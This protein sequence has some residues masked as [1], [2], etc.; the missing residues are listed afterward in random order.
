MITRCW[1]RK[2]NI[3]IW[4]I[5]WSLVSGSLLA[6]RFKSIVMFLLMIDF[7]VTW[8][9]NSEQRSNKGTGFYTLLYHFVLT[10]SDFY[11]KLHG[12]Y[13][14]AD[15]A[16]RWLVG[17]SNMFA[18]GPC[19]PEGHPVQLPRRNGPS[20][21]Q[22]QQ[23]P[24]WSLDGRFQRFLL[25]HITRYRAVVAQHVEDCSKKCIV[26]YIVQSGIW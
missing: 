25:H 4:G 11:I 2:H 18:R 9:S 20:D 3:Y 17:N 16:V 1:I 15:L 24:G 7:W 22:E 13:V 19:F 5:M 6:C 10:V 14:S 23:A 26:H 21:Q 8:A 12:V